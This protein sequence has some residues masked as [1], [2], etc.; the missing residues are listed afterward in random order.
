MSAT[1]LKNLGRKLRNF[2]LFH[3]NS[4]KV[5]KFADDRCCLFVRDLTELKDYLILHY[6]HFSNG[7]EFEACFVSMN[8]ICTDLVL[9]SL[10]LLFGLQIFHH[11]LFLFLWVNMNSF[12]LY[13]LFYLEMKMINFKDLRFILF[14]N[15]HFHF[16]LVIIFLAYLNFI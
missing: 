4:C 6:D 15:F 14:F 13:R 11:Y 10:S 5:L 8:E 3:L 1:C 7:Y 16:Y 9:N 12:Y 2:Y